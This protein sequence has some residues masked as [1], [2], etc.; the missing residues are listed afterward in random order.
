MRERIVGIVLLVG[1]WACSGPLPS[2]VDAS[3]VRLG[4]PA[5]LQLRVGQEQRVPESVLRVVLDEVLEDSRCP[6]DVTCV[7]QGNLR[8][9]FGIAAGSGPTVPFQ[10]NT[11]VD[12]RI[13]EWNGVRVTIVS[14]EPAP[15]ERTPIDPASYAVTIRV[16]GAH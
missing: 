7:W 3:D 1:A 14:V 16:E 5:E 12:P 4:A 11:A 10:L 2:P 13:A 15:H 6:V 8:A 9:G